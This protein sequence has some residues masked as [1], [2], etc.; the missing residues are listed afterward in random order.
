M[1]TYKGYDKMPYCNT[2][3]PTTKF[4]AVADTP[5][6]MRLKKNTSQQSNIVYHK[7]FENEKG[8]YTAVED[9]PETLRLKKTTQIA[10]DVAYKG[11]TQQPQMPPQQQQIPPQQQRTPA[12]TYTTPAP[13]PQPPAPAPVAVA[14]TPTGPI[15][16][17]LYDYAEADSDEVS[18]VE[19]DTIINAEIIDE[20]W[21]TGTVQRT[22]QHGMLPANYVEKV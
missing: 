7:E 9:D 6:N 18:F 3:Y 10:S 17:A 13:Q 8:K 15:Y 12:P 19:G 11:H 21:M 5:E 20:G 22:G 1:K 16:K 4:T 14:P 2:H